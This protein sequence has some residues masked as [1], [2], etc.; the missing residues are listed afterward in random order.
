[1]V[2]SAPLIC[3]DH[4][5][6]DTQTSAPTADPCGPPP[7]LPASNWFY[8]TCGG[9]TQ[10]RPV[11]QG[12][13]WWRAWHTTRSAHKPHRRNMRGHLQHSTSTTDRRGRPRVPHPAWPQ[14]R[15]K[16]SITQLRD[17]CAVMSITAVQ[18]SQIR[19]IGFVTRPKRAHSSV[20][21][22]RPPSPP[23]SPNLPPK[24]Q[25]RNSQSQSQ[26]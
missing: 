11:V 6:L 21:H 20:A 23:P 15:G 13:H 26:G 1:M 16:H 7:R 25:C 19:N 10:A 12:P 18:P 8:C 14:T 5:S 3:F 2:A 17:A 24:S 4:V 22:L 9:P